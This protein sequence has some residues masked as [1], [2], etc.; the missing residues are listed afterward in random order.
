[1]RVKAKLI[2][3]YCSEHTKP[4]CRCDYRNYEDD[5][6]NCEYRQE[7][8]GQCLKQ[9]TKTIYID[10]A[11]KELDYTIQDME[12]IIVLKIE[13]ETYTNDNEFMQE[14]EYLYIDDQPIVKDFVIV[15]PEEAE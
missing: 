10:K 1:M 8:R 9:G 12:E 4:L 6:L 15:R 5:Y 11:Y 7:F 2:L 14:I 13:K 3:K